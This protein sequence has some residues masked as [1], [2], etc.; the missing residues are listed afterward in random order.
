MIHLFCYV[1][2]QDRFSFILQS[3]S[4]LEEVDLFTKKF[5]SYEALKKM[6]RSEIQQ[7]CIFSS[8]YDEAC[9]GIWDEQAM[10]IYT[11]FTKREHQILRMLLRNDAF[12]EFLARE[13]YRN[14]Q[15]KSNGKRVFSPSMARNLY[16]AYQR[17]PNY[18]KELVRTFKKEPYFRDAMGKILSYY[19]NMSVDQKQFFELPIS[20]ISFP[21]HVAYHPIREDDI[22]ND[23]DD[24]S[25]DLKVYYQENNYSVR[26]PEE[27]EMYAEIPVK[28][29]VL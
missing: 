19:Q 4:T 16:Y 28:N 18:F 6:Y 29:L 2:S 15:L 12:I 13:D 3:F 21:I 14:F 8:F 24:S 9:F 25:N 23:F 10:Q 17:R 20:S 22:N 1:P 11:V 26:D 5:S 7:K 27:A